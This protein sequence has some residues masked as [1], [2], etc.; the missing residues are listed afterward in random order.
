M[1]RA[2]AF[3]LP[4]GVV[5]EVKTDGVTIQNRGDV[6]LHSAFGGLPLHV[7]SLE[8]NVELHA[9]LGGG[10]VEAAGDVRIV[11]D[12]AAESIV[13]GGGLRIEGAAR[14]KSLDARGG[15][16]HVE[17]DVVGEVVVAAGAVRVRGSTQARNIRGY[18][19]TLA[20]PLLQARAVQAARSVNLSATQVTVDVI[21]A[22]HVTIEPHA[23][24]RV[25]MIE[26][27]NEL[28]P[29]AL[30]GCFRLADW[31]EMFGDPVPW[32]A[33]RGVDPNATQGSPSPAESVPPPP[34]PVAEVLGLP[35]AIAAEETWNGK[36]DLEAIRAEA[37]A[38][39]S[40]SAPEAPVSP[41]LPEIPEVVDEAPAA[42]PLVA[43]EASGEVHGQLMQAATRLSEAYGGAEVPRAVDDLCTLIAIR[44]YAGVRG[45]ITGM[46][47]DIGRFHRERGTKIPAAVTAAFNQINALARKA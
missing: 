25:S 16:L 36:I 46:W 40:R 35:V 31:Q 3:V 28:G 17:G 4:E 24:G 39:A 32:L 11:G 27:A 29:K 14:V 23:S 10:A 30:K 43:S 47:S 18:E 45:R 12:A 8:G 5:F 13:A 42:A 2:P 37:L 26:C 7:R 6:V 19:V 1:A 22:P 20:G 15:D 9:G 34:P 38:E 44:D 33:E 21:F 41:P